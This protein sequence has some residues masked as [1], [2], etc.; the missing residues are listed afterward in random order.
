MRDD[1]HKRVPVSQAMR[2]VLRGC[3]RSADRQQPELLIAKAAAALTKDV[4]ANLDAA[5]S[6]VIA[7]EAN[8]PGLFGFEGVS[9]APRSALQTEVIILLNNNQAANLGDALK[10]ALASHITSVVSETNACMIAEGVHRSERQEVI[11][12]LSS[13]LAEAT[14][15]AVATYLQGERPPAPAKIQLDDLLVLGPRASGF[16]R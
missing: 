4:R 7:A 15:P 13:V 5:L 10:A 8:E 14:S 11:A 1:I 9:A 3:M 6:G 2:A 12:T 16:E